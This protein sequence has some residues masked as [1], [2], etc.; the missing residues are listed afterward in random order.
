M[1][2]MRTYFYLGLL[3][4]LL[5]GV[6]PAWGDN[7]PAES[8]NNTAGNNA[9]KSKPMLVTPEREAAVLTFVRLNHPEL[10]GLLVHLKDGRPKDYEKAIRD[11]Y[12][13]SERLA[14]V[15]D[16]DAE[17]YGLELQAWKIQSRLQLLSAKLQM[18][19]TDELKAQI[20]EALAEQHEVK[21]AILARQRHKL[22]AE[23]KKVEDDLT[24]LEKQKKTLLEKQFETL[25]RPAASTAA[26]PVS[27]KPANKPVDKP[28]NR[29]VDSK[30]KPTS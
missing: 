3:S 13:V 8:G 21:A 17:R 20:K 5:V 15:Q 25:T 11:L 2:A 19:K 29:K 16:K 10:E 22:Q 4:I 6:A 28:A 30:P 26:E 9:A 12:R 1:S 18:G 24:Q 23:A 14:L 7:N 27:T